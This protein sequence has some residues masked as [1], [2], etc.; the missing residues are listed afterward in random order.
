MPDI[1]MCQQPCPA[2]DTCKRHAD[3]GTVPSRPWQSYGAFLPRSGDCDHYVEKPF[4]T[5]PHIEG[6]P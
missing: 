1:T 3:S 2:S 4:T 6:E 5:P